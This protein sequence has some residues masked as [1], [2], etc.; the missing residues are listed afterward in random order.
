MINR[1]QG[2]INIFIKKKILS[3][4]RESVTGCNSPTT[5]QKHKYSCRG[6]IQFRLRVRHATTAIKT[7]GEINLKNKL[8]LK[9]KII[10]RKRRKGDVNRK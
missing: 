9:K 7:K 2:D 4:T 8:K 3:S 5:F 10:S 1:F 6:R